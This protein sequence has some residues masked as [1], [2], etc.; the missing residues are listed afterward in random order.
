MSTMNMNE[1]KTAQVKPATYTV[2]D[3]QLSQQS[4]MGA[5]FALGKELKSS[6][7]NKNIQLYDKLLGNFNTYNVDRLTNMFNS[8]QWLFVTSIVNSTSNVFDPKY[9]MEKYPLI[10]TNIIVYGVKMMA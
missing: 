10:L 5:I 6:P 4:L 1:N 7:V 9:V 3:L 8:F 2:S